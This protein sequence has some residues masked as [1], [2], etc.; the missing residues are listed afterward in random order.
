MKKILLLILL[1]PGVI[2]GQTLFLSDAV[3]VSTE[4]TGNRAPRLALLDNDRPIVYWGKP[5]GDATMYLAIWENGSFG[6]PIAVNTNGIVPDL[7]GG[8]LGPQIATLGNTVF[9]VFEV[10]GDGIYTLKSTDGGQNFEPPVTAYTPTP[11]RVATLPTIAVDPDGNPVVGFITTNFS[12]QDALYEIT[13]STD[14]GLSFP[15]S[16][17]ANTEANGGEVCECC[18]A[19]I[20][21]ASANEIYA[22]FR[23]NDNNIRDIWVAKSTDAAIS[24]PEAVDI[25]QSDWQAFVCPQSGPDLLMNGDSIFSTYYSGATSSDIYFSSMHSGTMTAGSNFQIPAMTGDQVNQNFPAI[26]G[27]GDTLGIVWQESGMGWD[28][29][30]AWS[31]NGAAD[32]LNHYQSIAGGASSQTN[33]DIAFANGRFHIV[34]ADQSSGRVMYRIA[35]FE[36]ILNAPA[37]NQPIFSAKVTPNPFS[38]EAT[39][40]FENKM[41]GP[42]QASVFNSLGQKMADYQT[43]EAHLVINRTGISSGI[44]FVAIQH[45]D[46]RIVNTL[47]VE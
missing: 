9:I 28:I 3:E 22:G 14:G 45:G 44:Y 8:G 21:I 25:D 15:P 40:S 4:G 16:V 1:F 13:R 38:S 6:A 24:F 18:P 26:A 32:L 33:P 5:G 20:G 23:N 37:V 42:V 11:G 2:I 46:F 7:W 36:Q 35:S 31:A 27:H 47:L 10:Y 39:L 19:S 29:V 41:V 43:D 30:M 34:Y 17:V 12:E